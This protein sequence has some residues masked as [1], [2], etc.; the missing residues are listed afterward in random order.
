M[1]YFVL[2]RFPFDGLVR[3]PIL[4]WAFALIGALSFYVGSFFGTPV[5][6]IF[7][8]L[9]SVLLPAP[10]VVALLQLYFIPLGIRNAAKSSPRSNKE[11]VSIL[12]G[13]LHVLLCATVIAFYVPSEGDK[14]QIPET[15]KIVIPGPPN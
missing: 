7:K 2:N 1:R 8:I 5:P 4:A 6:I 3:L 12:V 14:P 11:T 13:T 9:G 10:F 15:V